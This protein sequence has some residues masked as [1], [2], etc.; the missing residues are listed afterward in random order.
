V[1]HRRREKKTER[2]K[3]GEWYWVK[4]RK[5]ETQKIVPPGRADAEFS[6]ERLRFEPGASNLWVR[7]K[8]KE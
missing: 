2:K 3:C 1:I 7:R 5:K 8:K 4:K 6:E